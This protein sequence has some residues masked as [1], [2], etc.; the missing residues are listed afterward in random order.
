MRESNQGL[1]SPH[2]D[3][4]SAHGSMHAALSLLC[5]C[6]DFLLSQ[7]KM[8]CFVLA[9]TLKWYSQVCTKL[10]YNMHWS[11]WSVEDFRRL[12]TS[13]IPNQSCFLRCLLSNQNGFVKIL[14]CSVVSQSTC[15]S[16][17]VGSHQLPGGSRKS[18]HGHGPSSYSSFQRA[19][20]YALRPDASPHP[21][22]PGEPHGWHK[23][24]LP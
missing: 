4:P 14:I 2:M 10:V 13:L 19:R 24:F 22:S 23:L 18:S 15:F 6:L 3:I 9:N 7:T 17:A 11:L 12:W 1:C 16:G 8:S 5:L 21:H 20:R